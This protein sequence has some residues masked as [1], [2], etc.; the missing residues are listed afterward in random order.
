MRIVPASYE[1]IVPTHPLTNIERAGRI[2]YKSEDRITDTSAVAFVH[3]LIQRKHFAM[4]EHGVVHF[5]ITSKRVIYK[6]QAL[7]AWMS[8]YET[9]DENIRRIARSVVDK[10]TVVITAN[11]R[12]LIEA[13][14]LMDSECRDEYVVAVYKAL[15]D[16]L[17]E[18]F[19]L[20]ADG[21]LSQYTLPACEVVSDEWL[22]EHA[23]EWISGYGELRKHLHHTVKF[24]CDRGVSH[25][26]VRHRIASFAQESTRYCNY[27][28]DKF[29]EE[30]TF[31]E[32]CYWRKGSPLYQGWKE[33]CE[34]IE[35]TYLSLFAEGAT[36]QEAR[37][38]LPNS[39][40][41][42][43]IVTASEEEWQHI[44]N[45]RAKGVTGR[46][47]PS[48]EELMVPLCSELYDITN[49]RIS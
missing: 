37:A 32:P 7:N 20:V 5:K 35:Q 14:H 43:I 19:P 23:G 22:T 11:L 44:I 46:P 39:L 41:T 47:H 15:A 36:A 38:V 2:C 26:L 45:L 6:P 24:V 42:E 25:E 1:I 18:V 49:G 10:Y 8:K 40:K 29:G 31:V 12:T 30:V 48:M 9:Y 13:L 4:L 33:Q 21:I 28:K 16:Y 34:S 27:S 3:Q 17:P